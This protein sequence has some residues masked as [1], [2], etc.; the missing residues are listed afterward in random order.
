MKE[1]HDV[2]LSH[3]FTLLPYV[4]QTPSRI[5]FYIIKQHKNEHWHFMEKFARS[6]RKSYIIYHSLFSF[7]H[8]NFKFL[9]MFCVFLRSIILLL[10][11]YIKSAFTVGR[12]CGHFAAIKKHTYR[13]RQTHTHAHKHR[14]KVNRTCTNDK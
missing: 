8:L 1:I 9:W 14:R 10:K 4:I 13:C 3:S 7:F 2:S 5:A 11:E 6:V 12:C